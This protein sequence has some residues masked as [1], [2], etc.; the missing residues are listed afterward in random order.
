MKS[1]EQQ[2]KKGVLEVIVLR[3]ISEG[4]TYGYEIIQNLMDQGEGLFDMKVGTLYP[5]LYRLEEA[6]CIENYRHFDEA[7]M[8]VPRKYYR[9][10]PLGEE[11]LKNNQKSWSEFKD[12]ADRLINGGA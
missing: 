8:K 10:L 12:I 3:L 7:I 5:I 2:L 11:V 4:D 6:G 1:I 9:I